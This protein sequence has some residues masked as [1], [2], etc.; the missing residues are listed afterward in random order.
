LR[1]RITKVK[2]LNGESSYTKEELAILEKWIKKYG[3][4]TMRKF[5]ETRVISG[6]PEKTA[7]YQQSNL[8]T[9]FKNA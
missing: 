4:D 6:Y 5:Y 3:V 1:E 8:H 7:R 9:L 2:F